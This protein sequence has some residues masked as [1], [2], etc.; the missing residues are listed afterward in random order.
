MAVRGPVAP[1]RL[2]EDA[3]AA[4][5]R[6]DISALLDIHKREFGGFVMMADDTDDEDDDDKHDD[7][8]DD[9]ASGADK[10]GDDSKKTDDDDVDDSLEKMR[11]RM[12]AADKRADEA[13]QRLKEIEDAKKD[14]LT[15]AQETAAELESKV[16]ELTETVNTLRLQ[17]AFLTANTA[18]WHD[19]D[20][21]LTLA[22][23][24]HYLD[25]IVSDDG[26]VDKKELKKA[27][28]RLAKEHTYLVKSEDK[29][30][31]DQ[32]DDVPSGESGGG[33]SDNSKDEK[34]KQDRLK[35]RFPALNR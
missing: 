13:A 35:R 1:R 27:L 3:T 7:D 24:K 26:E 14:D 21:A 19:P 20:V 33:R 31:D 30:R 15:K 32:Q 12:R 18:S 25:D 22:Q 4:L 5:Q 16:S 10:S 11:K 17:N 23:S 28:E 34:T 8:G 6:G 29:K 2:S 9:G